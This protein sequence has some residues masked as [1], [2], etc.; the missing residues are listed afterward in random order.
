MSLPKKLKFFNL[1]GNGESYFGRA[2]E[3]TLPK[4]AMKAEAFRAGTMLGEVQQDLGLEPLEM[5]S[6]FG[7]PMR[8]VLREFGTYAHD[9]V[10]LRYVGSYQSEDG[11]SPD[12]YEIV[13]RGRHTEI[14]FGNAKAG[15]NT[16][17]KVKTACSYYKLTING[18]VEIE[19]DM[20]RMIYIVGGVDRLAEHRRAIGVG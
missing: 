20:V 1:Y 14:D 13:V 18:V 11:S 8:S 6:T 9:G 7:G 3:I 16:Q 10:L 17:F 15:D 2:E 12:T 19:I 5:E 4:L